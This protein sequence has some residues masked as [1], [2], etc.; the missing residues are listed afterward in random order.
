MVIS[1]F[2]SF[3]TASLISNLLAAFWSYSSGFLLN[4]HNFPPYLVGIQYIA[5]WNYAFASFSTIEY[6]DH[7]FNCPYST[8][9]TG[10]VVYNGNW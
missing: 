2:R 3:E 10:C 4:T 5:P 6:K 8:N 9:S 1:Y 7:M